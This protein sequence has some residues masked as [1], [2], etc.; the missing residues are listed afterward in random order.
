MGYEIINGIKVEIFKRKVQTMRIKID[1]TG[2]VTIVTPLGFPK[3]KAIAFFN[4][5]IE[6]VK[7]H[8]DN[9][10]VDNKEFTCNEGEEFYLFGK[11]TILRVVKSPKNKYV[12]GDGELI[13]Y[14]KNKESRTI[15]SCFYKALG[16]IL[17]KKA[18]PLFEK[19]SMQTGL[20]QSVIKVNKSVTRWGSCNVRTARINLSVY[21]ANLP[22]YCL[23]YV[24]L[25]ELCH[26]KF[27][28]H[29]D[30]FK[31]LLYSYMPYWTTIR[32]YM[33]EC[34]VKMRTLDLKA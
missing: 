12:L 3:S 5:K 33:R 18:E 20:K 7:K 34:G 8:L 24:V 1:R 31:N 23:D 17:L 21:L 32:T 2:R 6:L 16:D 9:L 10:S 11:V 15:K 30:G 26:L 19:W 25:H 4:E 28:N 14:V 27:A 13:L 29:G 22:E